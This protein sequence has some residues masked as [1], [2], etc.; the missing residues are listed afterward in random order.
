MSFLSVELHLETPRRRGEIARGDCAFK[1]PVV[2]SHLD[3]IRPLSPPPCAGKRRR[4]RERA[5]ALPDDRRLNPTE[6]TAGILEI[7]GSIWSHGCASE[8]KN[9][10]LRTEPTRIVETPGQD[11]DHVRGFGSFSAPVM[12][13]PHCAQKPRLYISPISSPHRKFAGGCS[14]RTLLRRSQPVTSLFSHPRSHR[15]SPSC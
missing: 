7:A 14:V 2:T 5:A 8:V 15:F 13:E 4:V 9:I 1:R 10:H 11:A 12:R 6:D 3:D